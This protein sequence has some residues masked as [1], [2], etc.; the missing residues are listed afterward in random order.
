MTDQPPGHDYRTPVSVD[1]KLRLQRLGDQ[2]REELPGM[3]FALLV[4]PFGGGDLLYI[5]NAQRADMV[6]TMQEFIAKQANA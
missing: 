1:M 6:K 5:S 3:G 4:F 2:V